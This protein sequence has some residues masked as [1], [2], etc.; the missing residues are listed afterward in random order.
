MQAI[1]LVVHKASHHP[2][3]NNRFWTWY[4]PLQEMHRDRQMKG[5]GHD[6][7]RCKCP[8]TEPHSVTSSVQL[9][10]LYEPQPTADVTQG[11][12]ILTK[13][14]GRNIHYHCPSPAEMGKLKD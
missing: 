9:V 3:S 12:Y 4:Q 2:G 14:A 1:L 7:A 6:Y 11:R 13:K 10:V 5:I 8:Q